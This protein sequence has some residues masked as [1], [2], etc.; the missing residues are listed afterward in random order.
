MQP[1]LLWRQ[2]TR[3][4]RRGQGNWEIRHRFTR[5]RGVRG[6]TCQQW[7]H[8]TQGPGQ[9]QHQPHALSGARS[10]NT[11]GGGVGDRD[12]RA[13]ER[14]DETVTVT[15]AVATRDPAARV[16]S[17][18]TCTQS[19]TFRAA[20]AECGST[21]AHPTA[22]AAASQAVQSGKTSVPAMDMAGADPN[23]EWCL[24]VTEVEG[25]S[26]TVPVSEATIRAQGVVLA[27]HGLQLLGEVFRKNGHELRLAG[28]VVRDVL[29]AIKPHD[30]DLC[31]TATP[32]QMA[33]V[34]G[35]GGGFLQAAPGIDRVIPTGLVHGTITAVIN[36]EP[37]EITTLRIDT[38]HDGRHCDVK[39]TTEWRLDAERRD[40]T[41]NAMMMGLDGRLYDYF[42]GRKDLQ[43]RRVQFVGDPNSRLEEDYLRILRYFRFHGRINGADDHTDECATAIT[44]GAHGLQNISGERIRSEMVKILAHSA[45][46]VGEVQAMIRYDVFKNINM[47]EVTEAQL[48]ALARVVGFSNDP[49]TRLATM[50][51][52]MDEMEVVNERWK[53]TKRELTHLRFILEHR[54]D[55]KD[56]AWGK[57]VC[58]RTAAA[59][60]VTKDI[61]AELLRY[62]GRVGEG[63][64]LDLWEVPKCPVN[65]GDLIKAGFTKGKA[66][67][68]A[69][70][71]L[72]EKWIASDYSLSKDALLVQDQ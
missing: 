31:T 30:I 35:L 26:V 62:N 58:A 20:A 12:D 13:S 32:E 56:L 1:G 40:L 44:N 42:N 66:L 16:T 36:H 72:R 27:D 65:G 10:A 71:E 49:I 52:T 6:W 14:D 64:A 11:R 69:L 4:L 19:R 37:Y 43:D 45:S 18:P 29:H 50:I 3:L 48:G 46:A 9:H 25:T 24:E 7:A 5:Q 57:A 53:L 51:A 67:G 41:V 39:F 47:P 8:L 34:D 70:A 61:V 60:I 28:G 68:G 22:A 2:T 55:D 21:E 15:P 59:A 17:T 33:G 23:S 63:D 54:D 38:D